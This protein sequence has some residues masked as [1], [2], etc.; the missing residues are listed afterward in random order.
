MDSGWPENGQGGNP[1]Q[2][3][4][5]GVER[6][7]EYNG[8]VISSW[9]LAKVWMQNSSRSCAAMLKPQVALAEAARS[10]P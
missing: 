9:K 1:V 5:A 10:M 8:F 6:V 4:I 7:T 3:G 2:R